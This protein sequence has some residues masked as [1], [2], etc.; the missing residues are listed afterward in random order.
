M[1]LE[2]T[3]SY[4]GEETGFI[5]RFSFDFPDEE[6]RASF[7]VSETITIWFFTSQENIIQRYLLESSAISQSDESPGKH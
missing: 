1:Q 5:I 3:E 2:R 4:W 6:S 7:L